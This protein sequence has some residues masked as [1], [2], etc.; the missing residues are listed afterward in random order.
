M[1]YSIV[2]ALTNNLRKPPYYQKDG[3]TSGSHT[4]FLSSTVEIMQMA[5]HQDRRW[6]ASSLPPQESCP[7]PDL[8]AT[9]NPSELFHGKYAYIQF[10]FSFNCVQLLQIYILMKQ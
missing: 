1:K 5:N 7:H 4:L 2:Y 3:N 8:T 10:L 6:T 9:S